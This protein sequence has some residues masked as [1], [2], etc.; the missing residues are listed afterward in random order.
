MP[1]PRSDIRERFVDVALEQFW[2]QGVDG[3]SLRN[4]AAHAKT[5]IG[6]V[7][8]YFTTK[9]ELFLAVVESGYTGV[10]ERLGGATGE[11][12]RAFPTRS[13]RRLGSAGTP[14]PTSSGGNT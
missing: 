14:R 13:L 6:M 8:Y 11:R 3:A 9:D 12:L 4:I 1:R 2:A 7:Y 5:S 10:L